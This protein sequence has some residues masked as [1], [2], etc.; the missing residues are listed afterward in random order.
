M[1]FDRHRTRRVLARKAGCS[2]PPTSLGAPDGCSSFAT[3]PPAKRL[4]R[5]SIQGV[6]AKST[7]LSRPTGAPSSART[8]TGARPSSN[9][10]SRP[11]VLPV[12]SKVE[13]A[14]PL[15]SVQT[16]GLLRSAEPT[17][18]SDSSISR[19]GR[20]TPA[21]GR[22]QR[23]G[24]R[25]RRSVPMARR[26]RRRARTRRRSS[27]MSSPA[28]RAR[29]SVVTLR[30]SR[31]AVFSPDGNTLYTVSHDRTAIAWDLTGDRWLGRAFAFAPH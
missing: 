8:R 2:P 19:P 14:V 1:A 11:G 28:Y 20:N 13:A 9:G 10:I 24:Y 3:Q 29:S 31:A 30:L 26:S 23:C 17:E 7:L 4:A 6:P 21:S 5:P 18:A 12:P 27:G 22:P 16:D 25:P 15:R